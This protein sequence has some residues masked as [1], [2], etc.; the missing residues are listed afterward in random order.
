MVILAVIILF[1]VLFIRDS[2]LANKYPHTFIVIALT[3]GILLGWAIGSVLQQIMLIHRVVS[4]LDIICNFE[5]ILL[6]G[7]LR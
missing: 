7:N 5:I 1:L 2:N 4:K 3:C 6:A